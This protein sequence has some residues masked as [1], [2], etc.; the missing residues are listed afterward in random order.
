MGLAQAK[1]IRKMSETDPYTSRKKNVETAAKDRSGRNRN[2]MNKNPDLNIGDDRDLEI[3]TTPAAGRMTA[4]NSNRGQIEGQA[5]DD[6]D[7]AEQDD[8]GTEEGEA[9]AEANGENM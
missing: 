7:D 6:E 8:D 1:G 3:Y 9:T 5:L 4:G 2:D